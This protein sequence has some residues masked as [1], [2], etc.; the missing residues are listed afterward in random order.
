MGGLGAEN[1]KRDRRAQKAVATAEGESTCPASQAQACSTSYPSQGSGRS[2]NLPINPL[3][4]AGV[5]GSL[6]LAWTPTMSHFKNLSVEVCHLDL[7]SRKNQSHHMA[8]QS[9]HPG[10]QDGVSHTIEGEETHKCQNRGA[11]KLI[12]I[13]DFTPKGIAGV[14]QRGYYQYYKYVM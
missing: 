1:C 2:R 8:S 3:S 5:G 9:G 11:A 13:W 6:F 12:L 7:S 10:L 4:L 14:F